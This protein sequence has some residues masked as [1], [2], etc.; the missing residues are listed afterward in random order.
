MQGH[1]NPDQLSQADSRYIDEVLEKVPVAH[2]DKARQQI[3]EQLT[4]VVLT[5]QFGEE[6]LRPN[7]WGRM[8]D[9][10]VVGIMDQ[11][12]RS[13]GGKE[14]FLRR[15]ALECLEQLGL[16]LENTAQRDQ[17]LKFVELALQASLV[18]EY[19]QR[20]KSRET[21]QSLSVRRFLNL[22]NDPARQKLIKHA[23]RPRWFHPELSG[24]EG[25]KEIA[26]MVESAI[27]ER[28]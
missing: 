10:E 15:L 22:R 21:E 3:E 13:S 6:F 5:E 24:E 27:W 9:D 23:N 19:E 11:Q 8:P 28:I 7:L 14:T 26:S 12:S 2:R 20:F 1:H 18:K 17:S 16:E 25:K 4:L